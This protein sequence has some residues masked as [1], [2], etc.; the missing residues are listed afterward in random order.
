[1]SLSE[2]PTLPETIKLV[3]EEETGSSERHLSGLQVSEGCVWRRIRDVCGGHTRSDPRRVTLS[4]LED[5][6]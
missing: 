3:D 1:M 6:A 2:T 4:G 5:R